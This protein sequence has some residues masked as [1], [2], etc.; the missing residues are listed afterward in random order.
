MR[1]WAPGVNID[2]AVPTGNNTVRKT[3]RRWPRRTWPA[4]SR[5]CASA[6]TATGADHEAAAAANLDDGRQRHPQR[7]DPEA[8]Q[9]PRRGDTHRQQ[10]RLR[11]AETF[12]APGAGSTTSTSTSARIARSASRG[13]SASTT[14]SGGSGPR[15]RRDGD[16]LHRGQRH[17]R[18]D[19][20]QHIGRLHR[21]LARLTDDQRVR[22]RRGTGLRSLVTF[23][24]HA[25]TTYRIKVDG[26]GP[27]TGYSTCTSRTAHRRP[28]A[29]WR[30]RSS[31]PST[32]RSSTAR[33]AQTSS[34]PVA[35]TTPSTAWRQRPDLWRRWRRHHQR[36]CRQRLRPRR[37]GRDTDQRRDGNDTLVGNAGGGGNDDVGDNINGGSGNDILDGWPATTSSTADSATT[38]SA[39]RPASTGSAI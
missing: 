31:A 18:H 10:Q 9:R 37:P 20:R 27:R 35:A 6:S 11:N 33:R 24:V 2:A 13:R 30:P 3:G 23:P 1:W 5:C 14:A 4:R 28:V 38:S 29:A 7:G 8:D 34:S 26:F 19:V 15:Q 12:P 36:R 21:Q 39:A 17:Q 16:D 22:R 32:V 25:G